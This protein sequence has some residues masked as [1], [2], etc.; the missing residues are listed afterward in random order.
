M[1]MCVACAH[2]CVDCT[3]F[4]PQ[5]TAGLG[6]M[7]LFIQGVCYN[8][9]QPGDNYQLSAIREPCNDSS[10]IRLTAE[11]GGQR[12]RHSEREPEMS[13][14]KTWL[15]DGVTDRHPV[16]SCVLWWVSGGS[17]GSLG[18]SCVASVGHRENSGPAAPSWVLHLQS[19]CCLYDSVPDSGVGR[20]AS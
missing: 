9:A 3:H 12:G 6:K 20:G 5:H 15:R 18:A 4:V 1:C 14:K 7:V 19:A 11:G 17:G 2:V 13:E 10:P 8:W 16:P